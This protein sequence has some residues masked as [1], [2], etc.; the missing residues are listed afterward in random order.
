MTFKITVEVQVSSSINIVSIF[1]MTLSIEKTT[2]SK[3][4]KKTNGN[5]WDE[6]YPL[7]AS[8]NPYDV[9]GIPS[10][11]NQYSRHV[12]S[13]YKDAVS[14]YLI[15]LIT[16]S[17]LTLSALLFCH[18]WMLD[19]HDPILTVVQWIWFTSPFLSGLALRYIGTIRLRQCQAAPRWKIATIYEL[20]QFPKQRRNSVS[21]MLLFSIAIP[22]C[23]QV[24]CYSGN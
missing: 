24:A 6:Y 19:I 5:I 4:S 8:E 17:I 18:F 23:C 12:V 22:L 10:K 15:C 9:Y 1:Q 11:D 20:F 2:M 21:R 13:A 3:A 7:I 16:L 14:A